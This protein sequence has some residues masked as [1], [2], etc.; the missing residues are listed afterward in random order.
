[1]LALA[2]GFTSCEKKSEGLTKIT[3]Y[4]QIVL[5]GDEYMV[6]AK[7]SEFVDPGFT[8][9]MN[10]QDVSNRVE[11]KSNVDTSTSG[12]YSVVYSIVNDDGFPANASRTVVVLD[13]N[14]PI[15]GFWKVDVEKSHRIYDAGNPVAYKG[16]FEF[17]IINEG[18]AYYVEDLMAGWYAQGAGYGSAYAMEASVDI[19]ADGNIT[20]LESSVA[21]WGDEADDLQDGKYDAASNTISYTL[22]YGGIS[23][24]TGNQVIIFNVSL[25]KVDL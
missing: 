8:A 19:D 24:E 12:I 6:V 18:D 9:T 14:D 25:T 15:E 1:M 13:L 10:G 5:E 2:V 22:L 7:G 17:L 23:E 20:L 3:Y 4:A 21:G 16:A 11:V